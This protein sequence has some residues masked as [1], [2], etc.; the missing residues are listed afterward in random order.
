MKD[1]DKKWRSW[2]YALRYKY[3]NP[4]LKP[5][6]QVT[7]T[8]ARVDQEQWKKAIQTW[9][10]TD[11]KKHSEINKKNKSLYKYYH[12]AGTKSFADI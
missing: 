6:Q 12:C 9:T 10:L 11:W 8:D 4:S 1:L 7:P 2:K 5:N 3:F